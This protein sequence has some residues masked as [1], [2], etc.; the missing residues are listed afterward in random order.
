MIPLSFPAQVDNWEPARPN[1]LND[2]IFCLNIVFFEV[3][4]GINPWVGWFFVLKLNIDSDQ[5]IGSIFDPHAGLLHS[6]DWNTFEPDDFENVFLSVGAY[7]EKKGVS[8]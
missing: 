5:L 8:W 2:L 1:S 4:Q 7:T 6:F 3:F